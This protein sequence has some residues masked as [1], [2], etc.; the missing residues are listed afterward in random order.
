VQK[1]TVAQ[2]KSTL[3]VNASPKDAIVYVNNKRIGTS[4]AKYESSEPKA[5]ITL[6]I[7]KEGFKRHEEVITLDESM[8]MFSAELRPIGKGTFKISS[9]PQALVEVDGKPLDKPVPPEYLKE[10]AEG[11]HK[12]TFLFE[13]DGVFTVSRSVKEGETLPVHYKVE[14]W[15]REQRALYEI[16][17]HVPHESIRLKIDQRTIGDGN[18]PPAKKYRV[19][20]GDHVLI[21]SLISRDLGYADLELHDTAEARKTKHINIVSEVADFREAEVAEIPQEYLANEEKDWITVQSQPPVIAEVNHRPP[22]EIK[23]SEKA[24]FWEQRR[25]PHHLKLNLRNA[26]EKHEIEIRIYKIMRKKLYKINLSVRP[27]IP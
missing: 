3:I 13:Q 11:E 19:E 23:S 18:V 4:P 9:Y 22:D 16:T 7:E 10:V 2:P 8:K 12:L 21:F 27:I 17:G 24:A 1:K 15:M 14:D 25:D 6:R 26:K 20:P 5:S